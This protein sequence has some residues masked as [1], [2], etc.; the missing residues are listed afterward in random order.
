MNYRSSYFAI[1]EMYFAIAGMYL[2]GNVHAIF[3]SQ[4]KVK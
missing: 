3:H 1:N 4:G 2:V